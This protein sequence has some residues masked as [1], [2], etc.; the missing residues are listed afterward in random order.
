MVSCATAISRPPLELRAYCPGRIRRGG[1]LSNRLS[2]AALIVSA[3]FALG[4][5]EASGKVSGRYPVVLAA[6]DI[7]DCTS[8][9][10]ER[11]AALLDARRGTVLALGDTVYEH[12]TIEEFQRCFHPSWGRHKRRIRPTP[13]NH[14]YSSGGSE[15]FRYFGGAAGPS[16]KGY[17][18]FDL[19]SW[20]IVSLNSEL[21]AS[22][23]GA[24]LRWLRADLAKT[25]AI[26]V[27]AFWHRPRWSAGKYGD[28]SRTA[29]FWK[30]LYAA[31]ADV[32]LAGHDHNYQ[33]FPP[34]NARG[35]IDRAR[36]IR[37][38]VVG[39]GGRHLYSLRPDPRRRAASDGTWGL[40]QLTL[41]P[42]AYSWRFIPVAG[43][44]YRDAGSGV[45][46]A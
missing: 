29:S 37:S 13:G 17:Y 27:L 40:L 15:Y 38:F 30:T 32:V 43:R 23:R 25:N 28:D 12:G 42:G 34:L 21:G 18:S 22:G 41:R 16:G 35:V 20:H 46:S 4:C 24:Q 36:G 14:D 1:G 6:G 3:V 44:R 39:T 26:C 5:A 2:G 9:G 19:G 8:D 11:T 33:R 10:D 31:R 7:A 45:C